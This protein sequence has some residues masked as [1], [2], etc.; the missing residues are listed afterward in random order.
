MN[1]KEIVEQI[2]N[3][4]NT[5]SEKILADAKEI[6]AAADK[7]SYTKGQRLAKAGFVK[8]KDAVATKG[9]GETVKQSA[10]LAAL[11][12]YYQTFYPNTKFI[13]DAAVTAICKKYNLVCGK[14]SMY[15]GFVPEKNLAEIEAFKLRKADVSYIITRNEYAFLRDEIE[16]KPGLYIS[17]LFLFTS[18]IPGVFPLSFYTWRKVKAGFMICAPDDDMEYDRR[19][20]WQREGRIEAIPDPVVLQPVKGGYLIVTAWGDEAS[21]EIV[22]NQKM[23]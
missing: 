7:H 20:F 8:S 16:A 14:S 23:N 19:R 18:F 1:T 13:T 22:V 12:Q 10:E 11:V 5:A 3:E 2:H 4:F 21:D 9:I 17:F 15:K 6:L